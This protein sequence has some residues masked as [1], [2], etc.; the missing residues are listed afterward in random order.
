[1]RVRWLSFD[2]INTNENHSKKNNNN[3][4]IEKSF[5]KNVTANCIACGNE[6]N[7]I[8]WFTWIL[9]IL[10]IAQFFVLYLDCKMHFFLFHDYYFIAYLL[11]TLKCHPY[12]TSTIHRIRRNQI[13]Y[14][15][16]KMKQ[17]LEFK[18]MKYWNLSF[19]YFFW[20]I[21]I[22]E[23]KNPSNRMNDFTYMNI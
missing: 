10:I 3:E 2:G 16:I 18:I 4:E 13:C 9:K 12:Q 6:F 23:K 21:F 1:M 7:G 5:H 15:D 14:I 11:D 19:N 17:F 20:S 8:N 22:L